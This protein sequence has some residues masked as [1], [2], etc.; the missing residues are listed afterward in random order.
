MTLHAERLA[1][2]RYPQTFEQLGERPEA[3]R[4]LLGELRTL[5]LELGEMDRAAVR[6]HLNQLVDEV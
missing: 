1:V 5:Y 2:I 6:D 4:R 3:A